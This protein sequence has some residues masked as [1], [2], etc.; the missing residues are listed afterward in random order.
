M[1]YLTRRKPEEKDT[2][3]YHK[4][5]HERDSGEFVEAIVK[6][7]N[8]H[9]INKHWELVDKVSIPKGTKAFLSLWAMQRKRDI[10]QDASPSTKRG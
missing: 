7:I 9:I 2:M 10:E 3:Y 1:A 6:E 4:A 5:M 8:D